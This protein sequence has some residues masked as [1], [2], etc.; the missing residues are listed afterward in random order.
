MSLKLLIGL[1][2]FTPMFAQAQTVT[3]SDT[4][5][6]SAATNGTCQDYCSATSVPDPANPNRLIV[7][8]GFGNQGSCTVGGVSALCWADQRFHV[9]VGVPFVARVRSDTLCT[10]VTAIE[11]EQI[12]RILVGQSGGGIR[13]ARGAGDFT[14]STTAYVDGMPFFIGSAFAVNAARDLPPGQTQ[15]EVCV[16]TTLSATN[17]RGRLVFGTAEAAV[18]ALSITAETQPTSGVIR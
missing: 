5:D 4:H 17:V 7:G 1:I 3:F 10:T 11:G 2:A 8:F 12:S 15:V 14:G 6:V 16:A 18:V 9:G 13:G